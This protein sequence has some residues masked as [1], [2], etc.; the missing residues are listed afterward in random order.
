[1]NKSALH[2]SPSP[3]SPSGHAPLPVGPKAPQ[4]SQPVSCKARSAQ[5]SA[6]PHRRNRD[7]SSAPKSA[8]HTPQSQPL[9]TPDYAPENSAFAKSSTANPSH[10]SL[11]ASKIPP[12][13]SRPAAI[14]I[15]L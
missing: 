2:P 11:S 9:P 10:S 7:F 6:P 3:Q 14:S 15:G 12:C 13:P 8:A 5:P 1:M 4:S